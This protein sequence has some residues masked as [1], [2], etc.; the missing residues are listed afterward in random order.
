[1]TV[2]DIVDMNS[3]NSDYGFILKNKEFFDEKLIK[4][5]E[6][7]GNKIN[8]LSDSLYKRYR[9]PTKLVVMAI[10]TGRS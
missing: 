3:L 8:K 7:K 2:K 10:Y 1:M 5:L 9:L 4:F 6:S